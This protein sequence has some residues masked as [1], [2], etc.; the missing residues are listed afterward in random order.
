MDGSL[1]IGRKSPKGRTNLSTRRKKRRK[2]KRALGRG[3]AQKSK[4]GDGE[5]EKE[6]EGNKNEENEAEETSFRVFCM[7]PDD[8]DE[9]K[10][11]DNY[12]DTLSELMSKFDGMIFAQVFPE[13]K[14]ALVAALQKAGFVVGMVGDGVNDAPVMKKADVSFAP[15]DATDAANSIADFILREH[16]LGG[17][18]RSIEILRHE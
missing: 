15:T 2:S 7:T 11:E 6:N 3:E 9:L 13:H 14:Y 5:E 10:R 17:I 4:K 8:L 16:D 1:K 18:A 12:V